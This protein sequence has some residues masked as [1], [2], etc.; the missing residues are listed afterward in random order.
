MMED[1]CFHQDTANIFVIECLETCQQI[2][3]KKNDE[4]L[5]YNIKEDKIFI[6]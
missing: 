5:L 1:Q 2:V 4:W 6:K 3:R